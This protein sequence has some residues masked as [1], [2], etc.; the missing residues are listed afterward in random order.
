MNT[1]MEENDVIGM[2]ETQIEDQPSFEHET[3]PQ[4]EGFEI[5]TPTTDTVE[6]LDVPKLEPIKTDE[7][8]YNPQTYH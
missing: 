8:K 4:S 7:D 6:N 5:N 1:I 3:A 2:E